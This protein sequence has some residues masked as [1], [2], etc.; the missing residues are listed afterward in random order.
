MTLQRALRLVHFGGLALFLG[1]IFTFIAVSSL[2]KQASLANLAF[3][4]TIIKLSNL[5]RHVAS[6]LHG[7]LDGTAQIW[8]FE[9]LLFPGG[10]PF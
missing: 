9:P 8:R 3:S 6:R 5:A 4:R 7:Y 10:S 2:T 1:S